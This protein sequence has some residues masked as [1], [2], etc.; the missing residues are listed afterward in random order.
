MPKQCDVMPKQCHTMP[1]QCHIMPKQC[2]TMPKGI[3][4]PS[5]ADLVTCT[6]FLGQQSKVGRAGIIT[7]YL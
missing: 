7:M 2:H 3:K 5:S 4:V 1:K 6:A